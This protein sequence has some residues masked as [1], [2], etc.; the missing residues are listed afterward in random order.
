LDIRKSSSTAKRLGLA[1]AFDYSARRGL[2]SGQDAARV[3][4]HIAKAGLPASIGD[5]GSGETLNAEKLMALMMQDKKVEGGK[6][7]LILAR[8]IGEAVIVKDAPIGDIKEF[9][10]EKIAR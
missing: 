2:C 7:T 5:L 4:N 8:A 6:L 9:L 3:R 1:L 10:K